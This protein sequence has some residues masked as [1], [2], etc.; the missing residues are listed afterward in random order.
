MEKESKIIYEGEY[1]NGKR[2][3]K[4]KEYFRNGKL[5]F[6]GE[7]K[8][9]KKWKGKGYDINGNFD[10]ELI[11]GSGKMK[12]YNSNDILI[13]ESEY[14][15]NV[16]HGKGKVYDEVN[17]QL[18]FEGNYLNG[19]K[20]GFGKEY[21]DGLLIFEGEYLNNKKFGKGKK[22]DDNGEV[23]YEGDPA[24]NQEL[25]KQIT[26]INGKLIIEFH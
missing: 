24:N 3:G 1:I 8:N 21:H 13:E 17:G 19:R 25:E 7:F 12:E 23:I 18:E 14:L 5:Q 4:G 10:Y 26:F 20:N 11:D 22:Y 6:E 15:N 16:K 2:N 9:G